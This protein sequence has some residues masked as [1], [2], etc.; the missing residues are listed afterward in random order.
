MYT[1][2]TSECFTPKERR[3]QNLDSGILPKLCN[4]LNE[5]ICKMDELEKRH[6][7]EPKTEVRVVNL[8]LIKMKM[9]EYL[10]L[11][12]IRAVRSCRT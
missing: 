5:R 2:L 3:N 10:L 12:H 7:N 1:Y 11:D 8:K 9:T 4:D 6:F